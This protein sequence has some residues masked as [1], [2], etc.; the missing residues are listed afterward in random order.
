MNDPILAPSGEHRES[1]A[2]AAAWP[3]TAALFSALV[4]CALAAALATLALAVALPE[5]LVR[6][7]EAS[8]FT[9][10]QDNQNTLTF[11]CDASDM[12]EPIG[13]RH[14]DPFADELGIT[15]FHHHYF[16]G[17]RAIETYGQD[18][19]EEQLTASRDTTCGPSWATYLR[20]NPLTRDPVNGIHDQDVKA[21]VYIRDGA[22]PDPSMLVHIPHGAKILGKGDL[23]DGTHRFT[24][25]CSP[26]DQ[27]GVTETPPYGCKNEIVRIRLHLPQCWS[28]PGINPQ[29]FT[30]PVNAR[31]PSG[32]SWI[33]EISY[34]IGIKTPK[35]LAR[36]LEI[37]AGH[38]SWKDWTFWHVDWWGTVQQNDPTPDGSIH[39][40]EGFREA[41][42]ACV[43]KPE[44]APRYSYCTHPDSNDL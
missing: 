3:R 29:N 28:G 19:T 25:N 27:G 44:S 7:A 31:C 14:E 5:S 20:W 36:P 42:Q 23:V 34:N 8:H 13:V 15:D 11:N 12:G 40:P 17:N 32:A 16:S 2:A 26:G 9:R 35:P 37:S 30:Y 6:E 10:L 22:V 18:I 41:V 33:P 38:D 21:T 24:F 39:P 4:F 43:M 1:A